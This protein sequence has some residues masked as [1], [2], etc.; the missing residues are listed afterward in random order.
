MVH[1]HAIPVGNGPRKRNPIVAKTCSLL[2]SLRGNRILLRILS[3]QTVCHSETSR[4]TPPSSNQCL[5]FCSAKQNTP[6]YKAIHQVLYRDS[7]NLSLPL[8]AYPKPTCL[9][10]ILPGSTNRSAMSRLSTNPCARPFFTA[11]SQSWQAQ[12]KCDQGP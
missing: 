1:V 9:A 4:C 8:L 12:V 2:G 3:M 6:T 7:R 10:G 5:Y 11:T